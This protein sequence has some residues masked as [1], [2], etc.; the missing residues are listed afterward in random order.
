MET[1][2]GRDKRN[3]PCRNR[4]IYMAGVAVLGLGGEAR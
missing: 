4:I 2:K 1:G 3:V